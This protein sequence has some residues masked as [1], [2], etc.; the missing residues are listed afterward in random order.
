MAN[1]NLYIGLMSG[2]SMDGVDAVLAD[3]STHGVES[4]GHA[5]RP[6]PKPLLNMLQQMSVPGDN[7]VEHW[8]VVDNGVANICVDVVQDLLDSTGVSPDSITAIG[9]HGQT[10]R[11]RPVG[12][13]SFADSAFTL[14]IGDPNR[15][16]AH[17]GIPVVA[18][19]RRKDLA[20]GGLGAPLAPAFHA[21]YL[22]QSKVSQVVLNLGGI[23][24]I[25]I[26]PAGTDDPIWGYDTGPANTL[27][28]AWYQEHHQGHYDES[29]QWAASGNVQQTLLESWLNDEYFHLDAPKSTGKEYFSRQ[30]LSNNSQLDNYTAAD[31]QASLVGLTVESVAAQIDKLSHVEQVLVCGGGVYNAHMMQQIQQRLPHSEISSTAAMGVDPMH[32]EALAFAWLARQY[33]L[34]LPGNMPSVTGASRPAILGAM[35]LPD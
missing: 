20:L 33:C 12:I 14:Q 32:V 8:G 7:E 31:I 30:W 4:L 13:A 26:L 3:F 19:F 23:A 2:T 6:Y 22:N 24:N 34:R 29:G 1:Q 21:A 10:I 25:T 35:Y 9:A 27:V 16:A 11:H 18:D 28:D 5:H 15:I 17:T